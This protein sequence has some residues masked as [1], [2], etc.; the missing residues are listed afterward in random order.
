MHPSMVCRMTVTR[1]CR[2]P[3]QCVRGKCDGPRTAIVCRRPCDL[4]ATSVVSIAATCRQRFVVA[5]HKPYRI[6]I[7]DP[8]PVLLFTVPVSLCC[9][10]RG[11]GEVRKM[12]QAVL[13]QTVDAQLEGVETGS[14]APRRC[15]NVLCRDQVMAVP[16]LERASARGLCLQA[17]GVHGGRA[18]RVRHEDV[19]ALA[20][21]LSR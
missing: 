18:A 8:V 10:A 11:H 13:Q 3:A 1:I 17:V 19:L 21:V 14:G 7:R 5:R 20:A 6:A 15:G 2:G 16:T 9:P 12:P 4:T